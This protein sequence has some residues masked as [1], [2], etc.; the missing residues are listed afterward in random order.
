LR[1][2]FCFDCFDR[3]LEPTRRRSEEYDRGSASLAA[4]AEYDHK[5]FQELGQVVIAPRLELNRRRRFD[6]ERLARAR[7]FGNEVDVPGRAHSEDHARILAAV[8]G[9][10]KVMSTPRA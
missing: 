6:H 1:A 8:P 5:T 4:L 3:R 10:G 9:N 2:G 7:G